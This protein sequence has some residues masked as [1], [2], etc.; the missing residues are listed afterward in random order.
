M[1]HSDLR[2]NFSSHKTVKFFIP[3]SKQVTQNLK[4]P[5][6]HVV[7]FKLKRL[8]NFTKRELS[9]P[10][11]SMLGSCYP[12]NRFVC[13]CSLFYFVFLLFIID[14]LCVDI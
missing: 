7:S 8:N 9:I 3:P 13:Q 1:G 12:V 4:S 6:S 14:G 10:V 2:G 11:S 5:A